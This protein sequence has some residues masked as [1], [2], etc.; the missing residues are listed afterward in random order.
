MITRNKLITEIFN[1]LED[2][3]VVALVGSRQTGKT[4]L[5]RSIGEIWKKKNKLH[6]FD[7]EDFSH[8]ERLKDPKQT[9]EPLSGLI[10]IDEIQNIP[11]LFMF[12]R[13]LS[14][15]R[16]LPAR[17]LI[18]GSASGH[19]LRQS[20]ESLAGRIYTIE[21]PG[22]TL[23]EVGIDNLNK[24]WLRGGYPE[25]FLA[26]SDLKS[27]TWRDRFLQTFL[28]RDM[29]ALGVRV[30]SLQ[31]WRFWQMAAHY[32]GQ[33]WNS[34][35]IARSLGVATNTIR[36]YLD[37]LTETFMVRQLAPWFEN[38]SKR[39][40]KSP[41]FYVIDSGLF[42]ALLNI[43]SFDE[44]LIHPKLGSS[45][46]GFAL[47]QLIQSTH[48]RKNIFYFAIHNAGE[49][50]LVLLLGGKKIGFEIKYS[51]TPKISKSMKTAFSLLN[52]HKLYIIYPGLEN[53][54]LHDNIEALPLS[55]IWN[56]NFNP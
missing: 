56:K 16:P 25:S 41:K 11:D 40:V 1:A 29:P 14:D 24:L 39:I 55:M 48:Q 17:F 53:Y 37:L 30:P 19:L 15:R 45:W 2:F 8:R 6:Y 44:L 18:L 51:S 42:H 32:H 36:H 4:T 28:E 54:S 47:N 43:K 9:L 20:S 26:S 21:L 52:L 13:V 49:I 10:I 27:F 22:L 31:L 23:N 38:I 35:E 33:I 5:A 46:E 7:L 3:P 50:D 34:S 12:L